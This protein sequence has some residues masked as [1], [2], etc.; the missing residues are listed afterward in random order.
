MRLSWLLPVLLLLG[1]MPAAG[2]QR[3]ALLI[4]NGAYAENVGALKNPANDVKLIAEAL[5]ALKFDKVTSIT[6]A[7]FS[8]IHKA[9]MPMRGWSPP[10]DREQSASSTIRGMALPTKPPASTTSFPSM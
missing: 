5:R 7:D 1:A 9:V 2:Q 8:T 10:P 3:F 4:G 6:D